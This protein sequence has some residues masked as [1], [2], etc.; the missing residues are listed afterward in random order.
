V[1]GFAIF[2]QNPIVSSAAYGNVSLNI[3]R[4]YISAILYSSIVLPFVAVVVA[5]MFGLSIW[6]GFLI[7]CGLGIAAQIVHLPE[8]LPGGYD[9]QEGKQVHPFWVLAY[10]A[11]L[12]LALAC[13][14]T[15]FPEITNSPGFK[16]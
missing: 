16:S 15:I 5:Y 8:E 14:A 6:L 2:A 1:H 3:M 13:V 12:L 11:F 7:T 10:L 4:K 9:N